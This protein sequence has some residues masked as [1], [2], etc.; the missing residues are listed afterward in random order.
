MPIIAEYGVDRESALR[1]LTAVIAHLGFTLVSVESAVGLV[2]FIEPKQEIRLSALIENSGEG[3][4]RLIVSGTKNQSSLLLTGLINRGAMFGAAVASIGAVER[5]ARQIVSS[6]DD[7]IGLENRIRPEARQTDGH[8][9]QKPNPDIGPNSADS[10]DPKKLTRPDLESYLKQRLRD[11]PRL[12][13]IG[14]AALVAIVVAW[15]LWPSPLDITCGEIAGN[16]LHKGKDAYQA[17]WDNLPDKLK[18]EDERQ[19][20]PYAVGGICGVYGRDATMREVLAEIIRQAQP[21]PPD[22][23]DKQSESDSSEQQAAPVASDQQT[24]SDDGPQ[25]P[26]ASTND[27]PAPPDNQDAKPATPASPAASASNVLPPDAPAVPSN[28]DLMGPRF[29]NTVI[30]RSANAEWHLYYEAG[31]TFRGK[32]IKSGYSVAGTWELNQSYLCR[33]FQPPLSGTPNPDCQWITVHSV[34][35]TW[36]SDGNAMSLV[37]GIQ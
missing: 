20:I 34:G 31:G 11:N 2:T 16:L 37:Q 23:S 3:R 36:T 17:V 22:A 21:P 35:D 5:I 4:S 7:A 30:S 14:A 8:A 12:M 19:A 24:Q 10:E 27:Q 28:D 29:G 6:L 32:E 9:E 13:W 25:Q 26:S 18:T 33:T 1:A 15:M